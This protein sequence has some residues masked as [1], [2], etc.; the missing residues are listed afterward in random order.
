MYR[1]A[2]LIFLTGLF[3]FGC[4]FDQPKA[5]VW[6]TSWKLY[7][8]L[9]N[10]SMDKIVNDT[11]LI[12]D[13]LNGQPI[14]KFSLEDS[15]DWQRVEQTDLSIFPATQSFNTKIGTIK[16]KEKTEVK[17]AEITVDELLPSSWLSLDSLPPYPRIEVNPDPRDVSYDFF[18]SATIKSGQIYLT[19]YNNLFLKIDSGMTITVFNNS[20]GDSSLVAKI[21]F[22][23]PI[24][25]NSV[26]QSEIVDLSGKTITNQFRLF[27]VIPI[28]GSDTSRALTAEDKAGSAYSVLTI[29]NLEVSAAEAEIPTQ[30]FNRVETYALPQEDH[31]LIEADIHQGSFTLTFTNNLPIQADLHVELPDLQKNGVA[32]TIDISIPAK[33]VTQEFIDL[34]GYKILN[35]KAPGT[36]LDSLDIKIQATVGSN[37]QVVQITENDDITT[38]ISSSEI[39]FQSI[40]GIIQPITYNIDTTTIDNSDL[41]NNING[42][43]LRLEEL[44]MR[45]IFENE[46]DIPVNMNLTIEASNGTETKKMVIESQIERSSV[47]RTTTITLDKDYQNPNSIVDL[48][49]LMPTTIKFYGQAEIGGQGKVSVGDGIRSRFSIESPLSFNLTAPITFKSDVDSIGKDDIDQDTRDRLSTDLK[50]GSFHL[51]LNNGTV[52]AANITVVLATDSTEVY[53]TTITDSTKKIVIQANIARGKIGADG[54]VESPT[55]SEVA[56]NLSEQQLQIFQ[57]HP[58]YIG[59]T[60]V[61]SPTDGQT[62]RFRTNDLIGISGYVQLNFTVRVD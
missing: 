62:V 33:Q 40:E 15:T 14:V 12:A 58:I 56:I 32:K 18:Q 20:N 43:G 54:Y 39:Q 61:M 52:L 34:Q 44:V 16:L 17:S 50:N 2:I 55:Q 49:A 42:S 28:A 53:S 29:Q 36:P 3:W 11:T 5:P 31:R 1:K 10:V 60:V 38:Q 47:T 21:V 26:V 57:K 48:I 45:L 13:T 30:T 23:Q 59:Q 6:D 27:Y 8:P 25:P 37:G 51:I 24:N 22:D 41:F 7:L 35:S 46:I 19:F 9:Q 4:T